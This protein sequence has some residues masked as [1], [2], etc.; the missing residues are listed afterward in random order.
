MS[1]YEAL[2]S[3]L[4]FFSFILDLWSETDPVFCCCSCYLLFVGVASS[5]AAAWKFLDTVS[6]TLFI[7][8]P[9]VFWVIWSMYMGYESIV[10][11]WIL[12]PCYA[13][14]LVA[15]VAVGLIG[16]LSIGG[17]IDENG[18]IVS[19]K[20]LSDQSTSIIIESEEE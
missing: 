4:E 19:N 10:P 7:V 18:R 11:D 20:T 16:L 15:L 9:T 14:C 6:F 5:D 2:T 8:L 17:Y 13:L 1:L 3:V 12:Y